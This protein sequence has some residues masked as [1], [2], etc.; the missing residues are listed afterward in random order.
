MWMLEGIAGGIQPWWH[1]ISAY[2]EDRRMY[3]TAQPVLKWHKAN[4]EYLINREPVATVGIVWSQQ[5][6]DFY[7]R[8]NTQ[9]LIELPWRGMTNALIKARIPYLPV[10]ADDIDRG[11]KKFSLLILSNLGSMTN[12]Q[13]TSVR[14]FVDNGGSLIATGSSSLYDEWGDKRDDFGLEDLFAAHIVNQ[15]NANEQ[16]QL[17]KLANDAYH[18]YLRLTP[19]LRRQ[20][21]GPHKADEPMITSRRHEVLNGFEETDILPFGGLLDP[22]TVDTS[23]EVLATF[24]PQFPLY[25]PEKAWMREPKTNI[26]GVIINTR[27]NGS[28]VAFIPA[29]IDR[30][31]GRMNLP[32]HAQLLINIFKWAAR[33]NIP[34]QVDGTGLIDC[35][36]YKQPPSNK[37]TRLVLHIV[38]LTNAATWRQPIHDLISV[39]PFHVKI[40]LPPDVA[41]REV[42][43]LVSNHTVKASVVKGWCEFE[44]KSILDHEVVVIR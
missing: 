16:P 12:E 38:N 26:P 30:Q 44:M 19:E 4:E 33:D 3:R 27:A 28:R 18:T 8:N 24:I 5:N 11:A 39:G 21:D 6:I 41:G 15:S 25:P 34:L 35:H 42:R 32:D 43:T 40:K 37:S 10:H 22:L 9:E 13:M 31:F 36:L 2:H 7:G 29:D 20:M 17:P 1:M 23:A 14:K